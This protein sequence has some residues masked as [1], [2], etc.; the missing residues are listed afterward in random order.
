LDKI[1]ALIWMAVIVFFMSFAAMNGGDLVM[2]LVSSMGV[3]L[4]MTIIGISIEITIEVLRRIRAVGTVLGFITNGPEAVV[5]V[6]GI[7]TGDILFGVST[8]LG[9]NIMNPVMLLL[10]AVVSGA[11]LMVVRT[12]TVYAVSCIACSI[13]LV[14]LF[15]LDFSYGLWFFVALVV[16]VFFFFTRPGEEEDDTPSSLPLWAVFPALVVLTV[17]GYYLDPMVEFA[18]DISNVP[19]GAVGFFA[20]AALSSWPEFKSCLVLFRE[21][22][23]RAAGSNI[24]VSNIT[25]MWLAMIGVLFLL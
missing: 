12:N 21:G 25:N 5:L 17:A 4:L 1:D 15:Y 18:G 22:R 9:S 19:K 23:V 14:A 16:T 24:F 2:A 7:A 13:A 8:P 6:V 10:A 20:L 11:L 3:I